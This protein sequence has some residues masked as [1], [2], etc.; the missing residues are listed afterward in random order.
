[1]SVCLGVRVN[2]RLNSV[3]P[4]ISTSLLASQGW[5]SSFLE[6]NRIL[7][8]K[9]IIHIFHSTWSLNTS[10]WIHLV[11]RQRNN[12][13]AKGKTQIT[14]FP[15]Q[16]H[17]TTFNG[18]AD[19]QR[20]FWRSPLRCWLYHPTLPED[21]TPLRHRISGMDTVTFCQRRDEEL[22]LEAVLSFFTL[23]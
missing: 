15:E 3:K 2:G 13:S 7:V 23:P 16:W 10:K 11:P 5:T 14:M 19:F 12:V 22:S 20:Q 21:E 8:L 9:G 4:S 6:W 17:C 1:M 18:P